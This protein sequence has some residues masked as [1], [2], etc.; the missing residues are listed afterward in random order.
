MNMTKVLFAGLKDFRSLVPLVIFLMV[1]IS[2]ENGNPINAGE[3]IVTDIDGNVYRTVKIGSQEWMAENLRTTRYNDGTPIPLASSSADWGDTAA[4]YCFYNNTADP[5]SIK[6]Y[7]AL[8]NW[9][10]V[11]TKK[12][13]PAGWHVPTDA[14]WDILANYLIANGYNWDNT[15]TGNKIAK[16]LAATTEWTASTVSGAIGNNLSENNRSGFSALPCGFRDIL[17][18]WWGNRS[19]YSCRWWSATEYNEAYSW[20]RALASEA[21]DLIRSNGYSIKREGKRSGYSVR[22]VRD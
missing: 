8:Y 22:C 2:C 16:S 7:G 4:Q 9:Y 5:D 18:Y 17:G 11:D 14:E 10:A 6:K 19:G 12:L 20:Y 1:V 3:G 21:E 15:I 13:A